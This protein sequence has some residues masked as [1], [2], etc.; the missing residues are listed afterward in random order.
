MFHK[1]SNIYSKSYDNQ[2]KK[3]FQNK[4]NN[5]QERKFGNSYPQNSYKNNYRSS[6][7]QVPLN[8]GSYKENKKMLRQEMSFHNNPDSITQTLT[9]ENI[10]QKNVCRRNRV[11]SRYDCPNKRQDF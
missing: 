9:F 7:N 4:Q 5:Y 8:Q 11:H 1:S 10:C 3:P 2:Y 6:A